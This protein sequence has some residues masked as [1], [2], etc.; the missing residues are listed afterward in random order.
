[1]LQKKLANLSVDI[2]LISENSE[3]ISISTNDFAMI[4][5]ESMATVEELNATLL[6]ITE[7][8]Q[9]IANYIDQTYTEAQKI[10]N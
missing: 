6:D 2:D 7:D 3:A 1:M 9:T 4:I 5:E 8:Q 10:N